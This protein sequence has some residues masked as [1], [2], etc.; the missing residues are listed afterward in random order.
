MTTDAG[1]ELLVE[2][3]E[4]TLPVERRAEVEA[5]LSDFAEM[6]QE[7]EILRTAFQTLQSEEHISVPD[8]YFNN[9]LPRLRNKLENGA[10]YNVWSIPEFIQSFVRPAT[11]FVIVVALIGMYRSFKPEIDRSAIYAVVNEFEQNDIPSIVDESTVLAV[12]SSENNFEV[13]LPKELLGIDPSNYQTEG[14]VFAML[15]DTEAE[16]VVER[17]QVTAHQQE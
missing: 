15:G 1:R 17:L 8:H 10:G 6:R 11:V 16:Q 7:V 2:Y 4:G 5:M 9:F 14:E 13:S 3:V 12:N